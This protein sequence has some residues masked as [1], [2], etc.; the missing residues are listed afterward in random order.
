MHSKVMGKLS[1]S[2]TQ[3]YL[4]FQGKK[5]TMTKW[6][7][8]CT[9]CRSSVGILRQR[10]AV[11]VSD[12]SSV[13]N[14]MEIRLPTKHNFGS[15]KHLSIS[16]SWNNNPGKVMNEF[17]PQNWTSRF[18]WLKPSNLF[19]ISATTG[20]GGS[21]YVSDFQSGRFDYVAAIATGLE[22]WGR[23]SL[24]RSPCVASMIWALKWSSSEWRVRMPR[25]GTK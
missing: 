14:N 15:K 13:K 17:R 18:C 21:C 25:C 2:M 19:L 24:A 23:F 5:K 3:G 7:A 22:M 9:N 6:N 12:A 8:P 20:V 10:F 16:D 11:G 1:A 4:S